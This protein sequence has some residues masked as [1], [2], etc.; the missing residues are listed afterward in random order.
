[1]KRRI[2]ALALCL[3]IC[4]SVGTSAVGAAETETSGTCGQKP[5]MDARQRRRVDN[6]RRGENGKLRERQ[7]DTVG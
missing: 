4:L 3:C 1:M 2:I 6:L 5:D 7:H